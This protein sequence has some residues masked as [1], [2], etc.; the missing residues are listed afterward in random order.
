[1]IGIAVRPVEFHEL[2]HVG[3][4]VAIELETESVALDDAAAD[5]L[6]DVEPGD[7]LLLVAGPHR[8]ADEA[9]VRIGQ[10]F[11]VIGLRRKFRAGPIRSRQVLVHARD[12]AGRCFGVAV[13]GRHIEVDRA[14]GGACRV[15]RFGD[16]LSCSDV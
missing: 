14:P 8:T 10:K 11:L 3:R 5:D 15:L 4:C 16:R 1:M 7:Q 9:D 6:R 13:I 2:P 12:R